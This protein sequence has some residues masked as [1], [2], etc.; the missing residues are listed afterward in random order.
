MGAS[1][2]IQ[3]AVF[4]QLRTN[5]P[6]AALLA[7]SVVAGSPSEP[8]IYDNA[9][10]EQFSEDPSHFPYVVIGDDT[11]AE[12]DTDDVNGQETTVLIHIWSRIRGRKQI[13]QITDA[14]YA[15][16]HKAPLEIIG[17]HGIYCYWEFAESVPEP[18]ALVQHGVTRFRIL[19]MEG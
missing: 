8:A 4:N 18:D 5:V 14:I 10:Q 2:E 12:F 15:A 13:K 3:R 11:A 16:L 19:T 9:P 17:Q 7:N 1:L 6:L